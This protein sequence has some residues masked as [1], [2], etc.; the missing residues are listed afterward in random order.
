MS[1]TLNLLAKLANANPERFV[2][3]AI[4]SQQTSDIDLI[5]LLSQLIDTL[6]GYSDSSSAL[7]DFPNATIA[8]KHTSHH[9]ESWS[10]SMR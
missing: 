5:R 9:L 6:S 3:E 10:R 8:S 7:G 4:T 2:L 1:W